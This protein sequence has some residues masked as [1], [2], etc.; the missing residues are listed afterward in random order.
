[1]I[2][3]ID[4]GTTNS[5][6]AVFRDG[7][8]TVIPNR[9]GSLLTPSVVSIDP[10]G[11]VYVGETALERK[12]ID[13]ANTVSVF[14][15][16]MGTERI[17]ELQGKKY[18]AEDLSSFILRSLKEDAEDYLGCE[19]EE[20]VISV[21]AYFNDRQ[22]KAT[23]KAGEL[24]GFKVERIIN[25]PTAA[26][27]AY[28]IDQRDDNEDFV[29]EARYL[30]FDLGGGT[31]D[32]SILELDDMIMEVR[33][34]AGDNF[35]GGE[36]FTEVLYRMFLN[37]FDIDEAA[38]PLKSLTHLKRQAEKAKKEFCEKDKIVL[39][40]VIEEEP[41]HM[42]V[43]LK[44]YEEACQLLFERIKKPIERSLR[45]ARIRLED[46][47][48]VVLVGGATKLPIIR[49]FVGRLMGRPAK[50][51]INP[52]EAI[53]IGAALQAAMK[54]RNKEIK[55]IVL[56]D[57]CP[58]SLGTDTSIRGIGD[59]LESGYFDPIIERNT[60]IPAS[61]TKKYWTVRDN[62]RSVCVDILQGES[63]LAK[64][65]L[66]LGR[67]T[68]PVPPRPAG[69]ESI[70]VTFTYDIN[71]LLEVIVKVD[72]TG[73]TKKII[74]KGEDSIYDDAEAAD[75][76][77]QLDYLKIHPRDQEENK[78][79][80]LKAERMYEE[81]LGDLRPMI[82]RSLMQFEA[83]LDHPKPEEITRGRDDFREALAQ[84]EELMEDQLMSDYLDDPDEW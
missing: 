84:L 73:V 32:V 53:V 45:D 78:L 46:I 21:P 42:E 82:N 77:S 75:R 52:D 5:L 40:A 50:A 37:K 17:Y 7:D 28:G 48:E 54:E 76:M 25:E 61:R 67:V 57:V 51:S 43:T 1:M 20:A 64:G 55:E 8:V 14:K 11:T 66:L 69:E 56:T 34:V 15:R 24:A 60:V 65:N 80:L 33:A 9:L 59:S 18:R 30:V 72:S 2:L 27:I 44:E 81:A 38:V 79:L 23:K 68:V 16:A 31:L 35:L 41:L 36:D 29:G 70:T 12:S 49:R 47:D 62:Q 83:K 22:R 13:P 6:A 71:A 74:I 3:G 19:V 10:A 4:L 26:A 39:S 63:R 58:Y